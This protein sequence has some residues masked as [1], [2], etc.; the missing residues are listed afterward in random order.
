MAAGE[1]VAG[2]EDCRLVTR[3][4]MSPGRQDWQL[5]RL[6]GWDASNDSC[7]GMVIRDNHFSAEQPNRYDA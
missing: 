7:V 1:G 5:G 6:C 4:L 3:S 2:L